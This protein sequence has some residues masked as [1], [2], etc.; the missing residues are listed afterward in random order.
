[1]ERPAPARLRRAGRRPVRR[2]PLQAERRDLPLELAQLGG[3]AGL[4]PVGPPQ[5]H[6]IEASCLT[7]LRVSSRGALLCGSGTTLR[8]GVEAPVVVA[9]APRPV[10]LSL[11]QHR[12]R[13]TSGRMLDPAENA[14]Q[15]SRSCSCR[16]S[17]DSSPAERCLMGRVR[18]M[19]RKPVS[20]T[21]SIPRSGGG[22]GGGRASLRTSANSSLRAAKAG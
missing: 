18:G 20:G 10:R 16:R 9:D 6:P 1:M 21:S 11:E 13:V 8:D 4:P 15:S 22:P 7:K 3:K 2:P 17:T 5:R 14:S 19:G 12:R